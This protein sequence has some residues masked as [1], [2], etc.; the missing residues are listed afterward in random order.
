MQQKRRSIGGDLQDV[1]SILARHVDNRQL[2]GCQFF[3]ACCVLVTACDLAFTSAV[4]AA[5]SWIV[6]GRVVAVADGDT[7]TILDRAKHQHRI[8]FNGI[9]APEKK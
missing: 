1:Q 9:D 5:E 4:Y 2:A 6:E 7:I 3:E 8:R